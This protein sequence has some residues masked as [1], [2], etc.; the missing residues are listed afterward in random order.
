VAVDGILSALA[1]D[2]HNQDPPP[3]G[4]GSG[5]KRP[6]SKKRKKRLPIH[7]T[8]MMAPPDLPVGSRLLGYQDYLVQDLLFP[9]N[10]Q[11]LA[12]S[13]GSVA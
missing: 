3:G 9:P 1:R 2:D 12:P 11:A 8:V 6:G 5:K 4:A 13:H 7:R 10:W